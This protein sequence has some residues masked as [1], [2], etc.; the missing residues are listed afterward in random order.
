ME[1]KREFY[2]NKLINKKNNSMIKVITGVRRCGKSYLL[3][4]LFVKYLKNQGVQDSHIIKIDFDSPRNEKYHDALTLFNYLESL[5]KDSET[6]Y[7][8]LDEIQLVNKFESVLNGLMRKENADIYVTGSNSK[9]FSSDI[10]T[11]FR[12]RGDDDGITTINVYDFL[13][14]ENSMDL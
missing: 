4:K 5:I 8:L 2:I 14:D 11:E 6:Y 12:G 7:F 3:N 9:F 13:L 1:F 10:I